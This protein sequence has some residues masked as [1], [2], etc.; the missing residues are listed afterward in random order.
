VASI[1][2]ALAVTMGA[3]AAL[4]EEFGLPGSARLTLL[5]AAAAIAAAGLWLVVLERAG[6]G[7]LGGGRHTRS[8]VGWSSWR[9]A[10]GSP[11]NR[12]GTVSMAGHA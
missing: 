5:L 12:E 9:L 10:S 3:L 1:V 2:T 6:P 8:W 11:R 7:A 4:G